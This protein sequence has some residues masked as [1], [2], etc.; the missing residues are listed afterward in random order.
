MILSYSNNFLFIKTPKT[1]GTSL[2]V[3]LS[4]YCNTNDILTPIHKNYPIN[5]NE[6]LRRKISNLSA[7]NYIAWKKSFKILNF[8]NIKKYSYNSIFDRITKNYFY[9]H[10]SLCDVKKKIK[11]STFKT[12]FKFTFVRHP[13][14]QFLSYYF[15]STQLSIKKISFENFTIQNV[16]KFFDVQ[17]K[18][19]FFNKKIYF[20]KVFKYEENDN[21]LNFLTKKFHFDNLNNDMKNIHLLKIKKNYEKKNYF[22]KNIE[23]MIYKESKIIL[24]NFY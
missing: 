21:S 15:W 11:P 12:L 9:N 10:M 17:K 23:N 14:D 1:G 2:E 13:F 19:L 16:K 18:I 7:Q 5:E 20:N 6:N 22:N 24:E 8:Y 3:C 4:K